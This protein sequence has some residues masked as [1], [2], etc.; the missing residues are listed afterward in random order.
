MS[1]DRMAE[2]MADLD[3]AEDIKDGSAPLPNKN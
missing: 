3:W 2:I 1:P